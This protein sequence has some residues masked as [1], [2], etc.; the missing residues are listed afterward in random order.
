M[1]LFIKFTANFAYLF[2]IYMIFILFIVF[3][4]LFLHQLT[5]YAKLNTMK[6]GN[7]IFLRNI[8]MF[9]I[10]LFSYLNLF[11]QT[12]PTPWYVTGNTQGGDMKFGRQSSEAGNIYFFNSATNSLSDYDM[13]LTY[14]PSYLGLG[15]LNPESNLHIHSEETFIPGSG[16]GT[17]PIDDGRKDGTLTSESVI[18]LTNHFTGSGEGDGFLIRSYNTNVVLNNQEAGS[19]TLLNAVDGNR[20]SLE[21]DGALSIGGLNDPN[22]VVTADGNV[23]IGT[24]TPSSTLH[25]E[26]NNMILEQNDNILRFDADNGGVEIGSS[27]NLITFWYNGQYNKL[28]AGELEIYNGSTQFIVQSGGNV[29]IGTASPQ[30]KLDVRGPA[31][32]CKVIVE[33]SGWCDYVFEDDYELMSLGELESFITMNKHL[34]G[35]PTEEEVAENGVDLS[36]MN[37]KL[38]KKVEELSLYIIEQEKRIQA[39][40]EAQK[41]LKEDE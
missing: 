16:S 21:Q 15:T 27:T 29:G 20:L 6:H 8:A 3:L 4:F 38:L 40:E 28:K 17:I 12:R 11:G 10:L 31:H 5:V 36:E 7:A 1:Y 19:F 24:T 2:N 14:D 34:P 35:I 32:F 39:L 26:G 23:G 13:V 22:F 37:K 9:V 33:S 25:V 41:T 18:Q 30:Y